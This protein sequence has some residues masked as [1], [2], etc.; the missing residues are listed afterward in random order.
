MELTR[1][2][3]RPSQ[4]GPAEHFTGTVRNPLFPS[5]P[6]ARAAAAY[7]TFEPCRAAISTT[8]GNEP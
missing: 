4:K 7:V 8:G 5:N 6:P 3:S 1:S 2:G